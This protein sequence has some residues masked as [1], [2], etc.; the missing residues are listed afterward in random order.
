[1][2]DPLGRPQSEIRNPLSQREKLATIPPP[3]VPNLVVP[4]DWMCIYFVS[5]DVLRDIR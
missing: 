4:L 3:P 5:P 1:V 2:A